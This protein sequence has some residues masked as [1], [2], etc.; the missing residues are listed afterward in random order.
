MI[1]DGRQMC[2]D[3]SAADFLTGPVTM[4]AFPFAVMVITGVF[5]VFQWWFEHLRHTSQGALDGTVYDR[6]FSIN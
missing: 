3:A 6:R 5:M 4:L 1:N 2:A